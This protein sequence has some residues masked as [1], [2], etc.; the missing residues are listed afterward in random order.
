MTGVDWLAVSL[1]CMVF[2]DWI[3]TWA[4]WTLHR[5]EPRNTALASRTFTSIV[6]SIAGTVAGALAAAELTRLTIPSPLSI[7]AVATVFV[8]IS[9]PQ[10]HWLWL[11][12]R[13]T[14]R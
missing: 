1:V 6:L 5:M 14:W 10:A 9:I 11:Y 13:G 8:F 12:K 4:L 3:A 2:L 7:G